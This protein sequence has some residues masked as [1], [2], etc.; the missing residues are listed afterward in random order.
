MNLYNFI[1][2]KKE[3]KNGGCQSYFDIKKKNILLINE[4]NGCLAGKVFGSRVCG[5]FSVSIALKMT[6]ISLSSSRDTS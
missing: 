3:E 4:I 2:V 6:I 1:S 5:P